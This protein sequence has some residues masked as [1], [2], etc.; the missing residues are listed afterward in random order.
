MSDLNFLDKLNF[1][2]SSAWSVEK[3]KHHDRLNTSPLSVDELHGDKTESLQDK[4]L[5]LLQSFP[6]YIVLVAGRKIRV[7]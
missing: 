5:S 1:K 4:S 3:P 2:L 6:Y 7:L